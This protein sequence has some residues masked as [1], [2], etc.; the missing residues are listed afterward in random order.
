MVETPINVANEDRPQLKKI[1]SAL[2]SLWLRLSTEEKMTNSQL[3]K[4]ISVLRRILQC[5]RDAGRG[6]NIKTHSRNNLRRA[7]TA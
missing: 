3:E 7:P 1:E 2:E 6:V 5:I 4:K